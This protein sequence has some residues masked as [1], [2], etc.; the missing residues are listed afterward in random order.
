MSARKLGLVLITSIILGSTIFS[1]LPVANVFGSTKG[2]WLLPNVEKLNNDSNLREVV[3]SRHKITADEIQIMKKKI[4]VSAAGQNYNQLIDGHGTGLRAPTAA[5]WQQIAQTEQIVDSVTYPSSPPSVDNSLLPWFPPIGNQGGEGS[6]VAWAVGYYVK[7]FQEAKEHGWNLSDAAWLYGYS[8]YP[9]PSYQDKIISPDFIYHLINGGVDNGAPFEDAMNLVCQIGACSWEKM[10]YNYSDHTTWPSEQAWT[11]APLYRGN[12]S[13]I[14][15]MAI[16][17]TQGLDN[18]KNWIA[19]GNLAVIGV[20]AYKI[21]NQTTHASLLTSDDMLT[22][23]NYANPSANHANT[24]VGFDDSINYTEA[25]QPT[26]GAFKIANSWG[27]GGWEHI[28]DG[29]YWISYEAM[30]Q[31]VGATSYAMFYYDMVNYQPELTATFRITHPYRGECNITVGMGSV[32]SSSTTKWFNKYIS[33]GNVAFPA[34]NIVLDITEFKDHVSTLYNQSYFFKI[35]D[36]GST[37]TGTVNRFAI[38]NVNS[39]DAPKATVNNQDVYLTVA[40]TTYIGE[41]SLSPT[42]GPAGETIALN[43]WGFTRSS[44]VNLTYLNPA[45]STWFSIV[46]NTAINAQGQFNYS[47]NA[48]DLA[49]SNAAGDGPVAFDSIVFHAV[50][51][52]N[53][54]S[55]N[56]SMPYCEWRRGLIRVGNAQAMGVYGN[57]TN[58]ASTV[59]VVAGQMLQVEGKWFSPG[60]V[61]VLW[62]GSTSLITAIANETGYF[63]TN[64]LIPV[65]GA[66]AHG[67]VFRNGNVDFLVSVV[68]TPSTANDYDGLWHNSDFTINLIP[69]GDNC[70][71]YYRINSGTVRRVDIDGQSLITTE[72]SNNVLE[73]WSVDE[74][75]NEELPHKTLSQIRLDKNPPSGSVQINYG[76]RY[77]NSVLVTLALNA[78]DSLSGVSQIR[79]S[80]DG[81][82]DKETWESPSSGGRAWA[83][84]AGDGEKT[85]FCQIMDNAGL[86]SSYSASI[87]LDTA[88]P[89]VNAGQNQT[90]LTGSSI[91]LV[92]VYCQ[93]NTGISTYLWSFGDGSNGTGSS[94]THTYSTAGTYAVTLTVQD[95]AGNT[96]TSGLTVTVLNDVSGMIPEFPAAVFVLPVLLAVML[97]SFA[98]KREFFG[99]TQRNRV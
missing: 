70:E 52:A 15:Y 7:T 93:D 39:T 37:T 6:C 23:D 42:S 63:T 60:E 25:G 16:D 33:G 43:G 74:F 73:Y 46:N 17:S 81:V 76:E 82:W 24:I 9:T 90:A 84:T 99:K 48:P 49:Q 92:A 28:S 5:E 85:V 26:Q 18:L 54:L 86:I 21:Q 59:A 62:D 50:D 36:T 56:S 8:G 45:T 3:V 78:S 20:D 87:T 11:E 1:S 83:L 67:I 97:L 32:N 44:S 53:G 47:L 51:N 57:N 68:G 89:T 10:P 79:F 13:G 55:C 35:R 40:Y 65:T 80:N 30:K 27:K 58:L 41:V 66:G 2:S 12:S 14:Q 77:T 71:T 75:G 98:A 29:F 61:A 38:S 96:A 94:I 64:F 69:D 88:K 72:G 95:L 91:T 31:R 19:A 4:G 22:L 34:N